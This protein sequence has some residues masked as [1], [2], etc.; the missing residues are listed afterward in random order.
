MNK[1]VKNYQFIQRF[2]RVFT[3]WVACVVL[4]IGQSGTRQFEYHKSGGTVNVQISIVNS[5]DKVVL[6]DDEPHNLVIDLN[7]ISLKQLNQPAFV[8]ITYSGLKLGLKTSNYQTVKQ[9]G[10]R[11]FNLIVPTDAK[12][13]PNNLAGLSLKNNAPIDVYTNN[14]AEHMQ[15]A[16][17][18]YQ[19]ETLTEKE[20]EGKLHSHFRI[21]EGDGGPKY[22]A[23]IKKGPKSIPYKIIPNSEYVELNR[24]KKEAARKLENINGLEKCGDIYI[25]ECREYL[26]DYSDLDKKVTGD[27]RDVLNNCQK[28][29]S[30]P[31]NPE[32][33]LYAKYRHTNVV[34][35]DVESAIIL[36]RQYVSEYEMVNESN[37]AKVLYFLG[38]ELD[39]GEERKKIIGIYERQT[40][41]EFKPKPIPDPEDSEGRDTISKRNSDE[42]E[43]ER[44]T[45]TETK[46]ENNVE[47]DTTEEYINPEGELSLESHA[48][49]VKNVK[50]GK[51]PYMMSLYSEEHYS[52][53]ADVEERPSSIAD[54]TFEG[55]YFK[56]RFKDLG[57]YPEGNYYVEVV[58]ADYNR[59]AILAEP[60]YFKPPSNLTWFYLLVVGGLGYGVYF[61]YKKYFV[62]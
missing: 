59:V 16:S 48:I 14:E 50:H 41:K 47:L 4:S 17:I 28:S 43:E 7:G 37:Y 2:L 44:D 1:S 3:L 27:I 49:V 6:Q 38:I 55:A 12:Y 62:I 31:T 61:L 51:K 10:H 36:A 45:T 34:N 22:D 21:Y 20:I 23:K 54:K 18:R 32:Q 5:G 26:N 11:F 60:F 39:D 33:A 52:M 8:N 42:T 29:T 19:I 58:D 24:R 57:A 25:Q 40:G 35:G 53:D 30:P 13:M 15:S 9:K 46:N 56:W